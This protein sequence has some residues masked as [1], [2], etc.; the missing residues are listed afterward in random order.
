MHKS[1]LHLSTHCFYVSDI[2]MV[3]RVTITILIL[4]NRFLPPA[5]LRRYNL[6]KIFNFQLVKHLP[7]YYFNLVI[8]FYAYIVD[9]F[10]DDC[11][12]SQEVRILR[13]KPL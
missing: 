3:Q 4:V 12:K 11:P 10:R 2:L 6:Y 9:M 5:S 13:S 1:N 8:F 7:F